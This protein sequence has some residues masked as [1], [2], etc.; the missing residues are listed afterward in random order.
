MS[1]NHFF[2]FFL[3]LVFVIMFPV[4]FFSPHVLSRGSDGRGQNTSSREMS[5]SNGGNGHLDLKRKS[6]L[7]AWFF[8]HDLR[9]ELMADYFLARFGSI[10]VFPVID[11][12]VCDTYSP[13]G[14]A[15]ESLS[16]SP[17]VLSLSPLLF[18]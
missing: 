5:E 2:L 3:F 12:L 11:C 13:R 18:S 1:E 7:L 8:E 6:L 9:S 17:H 10:S 15:G 14:T 16:S 4:F